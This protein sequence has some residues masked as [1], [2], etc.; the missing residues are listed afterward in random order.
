VT[1]VEKALI[2]VTL[3]SVCNLIYKNPY[4]FSKSKFMHS[5]VICVL[6]ISVLKLLQCWRLLVS[7]V[8]WHAF[9]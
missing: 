5:W 9:I 3:S 6:F 8:C 4:N 7:L 2:L 1:H